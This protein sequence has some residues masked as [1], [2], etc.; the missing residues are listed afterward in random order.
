MTI[1]AIILAHFPE[2]VLNLDIIVDDLLHGTVKPERIIV[3]IDNPKIVFDD[4]RV[5][6]IRSSDSFPPNIRF[7][8]GTQ[9]QTDYCFFLDDDLNVKPKTLENFVS[10]AQKLP[11]AILGLEGSILGNT[12]TPYSNDTPIKRRGVDGPV[13][14]DII[15]R[16]YFA[17]VNS[18]AAGLL[19]RSRHPDLP[20]ESL[21]DI[22]L[23][24]G[25]KYIGIEH[26][27]IIPCDNETD[28][29]ELSDGGVG[30]S[31]RGEHYQN[32]NI[33]CRALMDLYE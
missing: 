20:R 16:T 33:V 5:T 11:N 15:I 28:L 22:F 8:L 9:C 30:Q 17:P 14:V 24:L 27:Y 26:N 3:F 31:Y 13:K 7:A 18:L 12:P 2:R 4:D 29:N 10:Y 32:R 21:D 1:T 19:L 6:I 25:N 23:C